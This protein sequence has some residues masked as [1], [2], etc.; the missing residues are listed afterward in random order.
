MNSRDR[1]LKALAFQKSDRIPVV[2]FIITFAAKYGGF[3]L[4]EYAT[5]PLILTQCQIAVA[6]RFKIDAVYVDSDPIIQTEGGFT[7]NLRQGLNPSLR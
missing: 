1:V 2:P 6:K 3:R 5:N 4:I 7:T